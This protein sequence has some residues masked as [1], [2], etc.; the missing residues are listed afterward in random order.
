MPVAK[1]LAVALN[2]AVSLTSGIHIDHARPDE[3]KLLCDNCF[4]AA[5]KFIA[6]YLAERAGKA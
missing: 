1:H 6:A 3:V 4:A 2:E 5:D